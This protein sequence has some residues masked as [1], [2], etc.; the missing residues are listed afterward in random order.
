[1]L[2]FNLKEGNHRFAPH[3]GRP[4]S[5]VLTAFFWKNFG[6]MH[7]SWSL[8]SRTSSLGLGVFDEVSVSSRNFNRSRS[9]RLRSR[10]HHCQNVRIFKAFFI[11]LFVYYFVLDRPQFALMKLYNIRVLL[12]RANCWN[13]Q[14]DKRNLDIA[15][16]ASSKRLFFYD[17]L[18]IVFVRGKADHHFNVAFFFKALFSCTFASKPDS[19]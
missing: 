18:I 12:K 11:Y 10:L 17:L 2:R 4:W 7:K 19:F 15:V 13:F 3:C 6:K 8:E 14:T 9:R 5:E 1:M 16:S